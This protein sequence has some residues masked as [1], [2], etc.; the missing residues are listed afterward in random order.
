M[1]TLLIIFLIY[2]LLY[3]ISLLDVVLDVIIE[4]I[5]SE[6]FAPLIISFYSILWTVSYF[7][8]KI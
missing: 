1:N 6:Y 2:G 3:L 5:G 8:D 7:T 4:S